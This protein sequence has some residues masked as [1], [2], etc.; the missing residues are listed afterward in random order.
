[1]FAASIFLSVR[2]YYWSSVHAECNGGSTWQENRWE[3]LIWESEQLC[4][5]KS[6]TLTFS[7]SSSSTQ[8]LPRDSY[9]NISLAFS[10]S[11]NEHSIH[12]VDI[13]GHISIRNN[14][15]LPIRKRALLFWGRIKSTTTSGKPRGSHAYGDFK[16]AFN[17]IVLFIFWVLCHKFHAV[18]WAPQFQMWFAA[19]HRELLSKKR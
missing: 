9:S 8:H 13:T 3:S 5:N 17:L 19:E 4:S 6:G 16:F 18:L 7:S 15:L 2:L 12:S 10:R 1:M 11:L 14:K